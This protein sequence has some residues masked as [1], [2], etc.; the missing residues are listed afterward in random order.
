VEEAT[1]IG[2]PVTLEYYQ[3]AK[4]DWPATTDSY[5]GAR[6]SGRGVLLDLG[7]HV[8]DLACWW[9]GG[10]PKL[11][12]YQDDSRG[13]TEAVARLLFEKDG[14]RGLIHLSWLSR[15][16]NSYR[17]TGDEGAIEG[18]LYDERSVTL[19]GLDGQRTVMKANGKVDVANEMIDSFLTAIQGRDSPAV[20]AGDVA[21]SIALIEECYETRV[22]LEM[23]WFADASSGSLE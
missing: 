20:S 11:V 6:G 23:P 19:I 8:V 12:S 4:F 5:F 1:L 16:Q 15:L 3:G 21:D 7:A 22:A 14:C 10:K 17:I 18:R 2:R 9:L 13:G